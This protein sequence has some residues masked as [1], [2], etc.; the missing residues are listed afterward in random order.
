MLDFTICLAGI[1]IGICC[2]YDRTRNY[3]ADYLTRKP[4]DFYI[5]CHQEDLLREQELARKADP[6]CNCISPALLE[7]A[8]VYRKIADRMIEYDTLL[9]HGSVVSV[10]GQGYLFTAPSG[11]G[12]ST[13]VRLWRE[14]FGDR[15]VTV[16]DDKPLLKITQTGVYACGTPWNGK[17]RLGTNTQVPLAGLCVLS[18]GQENR[19]RPIPS[20]EALPILLQQCHRPRDPMAM[21]RV[22]ALLDRLTSLTGLYALA[23]N[24]EPDAALVAYEGMKRKDDAL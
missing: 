11:T 18:R 4:A 15:A 20:R 5:T 14:A 7:Q 3:C 21:A 17:H 12:K 8:A 13:H 6:D 16:N 2:Q 23:C 9:F 22:L 1:R 10:D 19:I 24:M